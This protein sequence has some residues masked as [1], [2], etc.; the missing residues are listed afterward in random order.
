M[1]DYLTHF[2]CLLDVGTPGN[3]ESALDLYRAFMAEASRNGEPRDGF[4]LSIHPDGGGTQLWIRDDV[5]GDP[6]QVISFVRHCAEGFGLSGRWGFQ[7]ANVCSRPNI[8]AFSGGAHVLELS[9]LKTIARADT[10]QWLAHALTRGG[11]KRSAR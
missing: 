7:W 11:S 9:S 6:L 2:S 1:A 4:R 10:N 5:S 3:T 8:N